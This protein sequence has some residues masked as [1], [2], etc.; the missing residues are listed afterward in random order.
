[1]VFTN[2]MVNC[3]YGSY[4]YRLGL[5][6]YF[7]F[8]VKRGKYNMLFFDPEGGSQNATLVVVVVAVVL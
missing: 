4:S 5:L 1:M 2:M 6:T 8:T 7:R 3:S